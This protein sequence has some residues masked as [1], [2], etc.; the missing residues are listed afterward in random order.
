MPTSWWHRA[1]GPDQA[2]CPR[3][4]RFLIDIGWLTPDGRSTG[5]AFGRVERNGCNLCVLGLVP[6][7]R[8]TA[9]LLASG[10]DQDFNATAELALRLRDLT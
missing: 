2:P 8:R 9:F 6:V 5:R 4:E 1:P 10:P 7:T 3:C